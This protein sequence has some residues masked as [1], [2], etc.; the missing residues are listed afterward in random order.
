MYEKYTYDV[1]K[2]A[3]RT[4]IV[5]GS[6]NQI[7]SFGGGTQYAENATTSPATGTLMLGRYK[8]SAPTLTDGQM[9]EPMLNPYG[10]MLA[11]TGY[12]PAATLQNAA[13]ATGNGST[14]DTRGMTT[15]LLS[16][17]GITSAT[18]TVEGKDPAGNYQTLRV[19]ATGTNSIATSITADGIY[20]VQC[21]GFSDCRARISAYTSGTITAT[22]VASAAANK[23]SVQ[24]VA[25]NE[26]LDSTNDSI[27]S[28]EK[29]WTYTKLTAS[30]QVSAGTCLVG[31]YTCEASSSGTL[32]LY[33]NIA[34]SGNTVGANAANL[35]ANTPVFFSKPIICTTGLYASIGGTSATINVLTRAISK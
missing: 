14:I 32:T 16:V 1:A 6:G 10:Q 20:E 11:A 19:K 27:S 25:F 28:W 24:S 7:T 8:S 17:V 23:A 26:Q 5:D 9:Y 22:A 12:T 2:T 21:A 18:I 35:T 15:L 34:A 3:F 29:G 4:E 33:D 31:G 13:V 30:G